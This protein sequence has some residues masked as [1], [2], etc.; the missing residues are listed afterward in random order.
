MTNSGLASRALLV[1]TAVLFSTGGAAVKAISLSGWQVAS[2]RSGVAAAALAVL[3]PEARRIHWRLLPAG[4]C[5]AATLICFVLATKLTTAANAIFLQATAPLYVLALSPLLPGERPRRSDFVLMT[6]V[7][8]AMLLLVAAPQPALATA[9]D[10][11]RGNLLGAASGLAW[12]LTI[13]GLRR[14]SR[15][16]GSAGGSLATVLA[17]NLIACLATLP[18][19]LPVTSIDFACAAA[20]LYLG[21]FQIGL[22]Y[23]CFSRAISHVR[24][25]EA[26]AILL[27]EPVLNPVWTWMLHGEMPGAASIAAGALLLTA[28]LVNA[29]W[30]VTRARTM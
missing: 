3:V 10:P 6:A 13:V 16:T 19:A 29:W 1:L 4:A 18:A 23:W 14:A 27:L 5:Y 8:V 2:L 21:V 12:A 11:V 24:A 9:P 20:I 15:S 7:A 30:Q 25:L 28:T 26:S 17:G 22:A